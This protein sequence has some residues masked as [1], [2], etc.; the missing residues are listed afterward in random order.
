[1]E[2]REKEHPFRACP[3]YG[4]YIYSLKDKMDE[5]KKCRLTATGY[6]SLLRDRARI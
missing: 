4:P 2:Q 6:R 1:L 5:A 3:T